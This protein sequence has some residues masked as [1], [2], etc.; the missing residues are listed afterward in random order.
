MDRYDV[1]VI[2]GG[3]AGMFAAGF[4]AA[5]G[6]RVALLEKNARCGAKLLITGKG[7]CNVSNSE[8]DPRRFAEH[9]GRDGRALLTAL[10]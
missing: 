3:P 1:I 2:G 7:R 4:A 5:A 6:A 8:S 9:F 10:Y